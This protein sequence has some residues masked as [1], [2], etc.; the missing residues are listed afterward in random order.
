[1]VCKLQRCAAHTASLHVQVAGVG[2][3]L[4]VVNQGLPD[5]GYNVAR[6]L[7]NLNIVNILNVLPFNIGLDT[8][9][10]FGSCNG[11]QGQEILLLEDSEDKHSASGIIQLDE[12]NLVSVLSMISLAQDPDPDVHVHASLLL[13]L[14]VQNILDIRHHPG[15]VLGVL[16]EGGEDGLHHHSP[17]ILLLRLDEVLLLLHLLHQ[18]WLFVS[19]LVLHLLDAEE[20]YLEVR[21]RNLFGGRHLRLV[22][23]CSSQGMN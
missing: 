22:V 17:D 21:G 13:K 5:V 18:S 7:Q 1:M 16:L 10:H 14:L 23:S 12:D 2:G 11:S 15:H 6:N 8:L 20:V 3:H 4:P 9:G 19:V